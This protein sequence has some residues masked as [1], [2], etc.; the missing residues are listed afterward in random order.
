[1]TPAIPPG[2]AGLPILGSYLSV[3]QDPTGL[4]TEG[5]QRWGNIVGYRFGPFRFL[6]LNDPDAVQH[7]LV[8]NHRNYVKSRSYAGLRLV[9]GNGLVTS[10]GELWR[11]QRKLSQPAFHRQ[12]LAT[13]V[14]T[15][16]RCTTEAL[17]GW[18]RRT[19]PEIDVHAEMMRLTLRIVGHTLF[20]TELSDDAGELGPAITVAI[21]RANQEAEA[22]IRL[23][24][25]LPT[26]MNV[27]F[28]RARRRL[29]ATIH[30]IIAERRRG[31]HDASDVLGMLMAATDDV[32]NTGMTNEQLRDEVMTLFLAGHETIAT[33]MSWTWMLL[34]RHPEVAARVREEAQQVL[35]GRTATF[36]DLDRLPHIGRVI[37]ESMRLYPPVWIMERQA[38][39]DD[40]IAGYAVPKGT[41][42]AVC[43]WTLHRNPALW[44]DPLR[45]DPDRWLPERS[46]D[47]HRYAFVPF[48]AGPRVCIGNQF[49]L[50]EAKVLLSTIAMRYAIDVDPSFD[51]A[52]EA[53]V[54][55]RPKPSMPATLRRLT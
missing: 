11:R 37:D 32:D 27:K 16:T 22:F 14:D 38:L 30:R 54:T 17:D 18:D 4:F 40:E 50:M 2:P 53:G 1:V 55:L 49:A 48:G 9:L 6:V 24:L 25:W 51:E 45:F 44:E 36:A 47:R 19:K 31:S 39:E 7:V 8:K 42:V 33:A 15:M 46:A 34:S 28:K 35:E 21:Q 26:P 43:T 20:S 3:W 41:I 52:F 10:E 12:R 5:R 13:F 29:D 23:P